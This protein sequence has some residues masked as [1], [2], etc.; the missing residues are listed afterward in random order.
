MT[1]FVAARRQLI[2]PTAAPTGPALFL[3]A[4]PDPDAF[5]QAV[6]G[7]TVEHVES[8][9]TLVNASSMAAILHFFIGHVCFSSDA[10]R[11]GELKDILINAA[12][13]DDCVGK[14]PIGA[15]WT[16]A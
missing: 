1:A 15:K 12:V 9:A 4:S 3:A 8:I 10:L 2:L 13:V 6:A 7:P 14:L 16:L 11:M 5:A